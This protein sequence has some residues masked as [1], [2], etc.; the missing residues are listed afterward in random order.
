MSR[1]AATA[2]FYPVGKAILSLSSIFEIK[3]VIFQQKKTSNKTAVIAIY[4]LFD[5]N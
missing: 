5:R 3:S 1:L 4:R 2:T